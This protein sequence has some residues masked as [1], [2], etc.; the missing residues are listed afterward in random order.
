MTEQNEPITFETLCET[1]DD[2][3]VLPKGTEAYAKCPWCGKMPFDDRGRQARHFHFGRFGQYEFGKCFVCGNNAGYVGIYRK[4]TGEDVDYVPQ[5]RS[6]PQRKEAPAPFWQEH[7]ITLLA[8]Y[9][10]RGDRLNLWQ[11][12]KPISMDTLRTYKFG[13]GVLPYVLTH[14]PTGSE[15]EVL[16]FAPDGREP[17]VHI[18][19]RQTGA[20]RRGDDYSMMRTIHDICGNYEPPQHEERLI[21]PLF[22]EH[23]AL[24][25]LRGRSMNPREKRYK[26]MSASDSVTPIFGVEHVQPGD[27]VVLGENFVDAAMVGQCLPGMSGVAL[28]TARTIRTEEIE[29]MKERKPSTVLIMLD[30]DMAGQAQGATLEQL[31]SEYEA[32]HGRKA[33]PPLHGPRCAQALREAG[34]DAVVFDWEKADAPPQAGVDWA[35]ING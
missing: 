4:A 14:K 5:E 19:S 27:T 35:L 29:R 28:G 31:K 6:T 12:Y 11:T 30:N 32:K 24:V 15:F 18:K 17:Q 16:T 9:Q 3:I 22:D 20:E 8:S 13:V 1:L 34:L 7:A 33:D 25:G 10:Q 23:G 21:V 26:W 2:V